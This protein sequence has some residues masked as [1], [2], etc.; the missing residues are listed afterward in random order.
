MCAIIFYTPKDKQ[1]LR[2]TKLVRNWLNVTE[3]F[4]GQILQNL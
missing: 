4:F 3:D 1:F 2:K